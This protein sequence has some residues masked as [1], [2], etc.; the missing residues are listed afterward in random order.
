[1]TTAKLSTVSA[2]KSISLA[3]IPLKIKKY[4]Q[5]YVLNDAEGKLY[6]SGS[7]AECLS[8]AMEYSTINT[9]ETQMS[10]TVMDGFDQDLNEILKDKEEELGKKLRFSHWNKSDRVYVAGGHEYIL[11]TVESDY[12][13]EY[14]E[15]V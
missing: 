5:T 2:N 12:R 1:M 7:V 10:F 6:H 13:I 14:Y 3:G 4:G 11:Y 8:Y 9:Q 15:W